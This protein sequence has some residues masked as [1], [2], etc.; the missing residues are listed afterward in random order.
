MEFS[1]QEYWSGTP[2]PIA[3][4]LP[5]SGIKLPSLDPPALADGFSTTSATWEAPGGF[6]A[7][8]ASRGKE[9]TVHSEQLEG[10]TANT[11]APN[12]PPKH[13][14]EN[15]QAETQ[16]VLRSSWSLQYSISGMA[17]APRQSEEGATGTAQ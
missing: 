9:D 6:T 8:K 5:A 14:E 2:F 3:G 17:R 15:A 10:K 1:T 13:A 7:E 11:G 4:N 16:S 12:R